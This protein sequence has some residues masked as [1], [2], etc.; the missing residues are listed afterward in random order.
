[1]VFGSSGSAL[2]RRMKSLAAGLRA[3]GQTCVTDPIR[4]IPA[5]RCLIGSGLLRLTTSASLT[6]GLQ[7]GS[8]SQRF[9]DSPPDCYHGNRGN[10]EV[11]GYK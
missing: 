3:R 11:A 5:P 7:G 6:G 10:N 4:G 1:M 2:Q 8:L 9:L